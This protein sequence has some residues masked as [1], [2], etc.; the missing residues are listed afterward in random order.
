MISV[1]ARKS[2]LSAS[3]TSNSPAASADAIRRAW[4]SCSSSS[5]ASQ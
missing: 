2:L 1:M 5:K 3:S 4:R